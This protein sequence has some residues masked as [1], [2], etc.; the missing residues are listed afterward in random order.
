MY[1][2]SFP[3]FF[4]RPSF[5]PSVC[6]CGA[7]GYWDQWFLLCAA[8][9]LR[10][11]AFWSL[12][13]VAQQSNTSLPLLLVQITNP[14]LQ[15]SSVHIMP[16]S[17]A[18]KVWNQPRTNKLSL[19]VPGPCLHLPSLILAL[20]DHFNFTFVFFS[21]PFYRRRTW[22][23]FLSHKDSTSRKL[24]RWIHQLIWSVLNSGWIQSPTPIQSKWRELNFSEAKTYA[25]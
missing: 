18:L 12:T 21:F 2:S 10:H 3:P 14:S 4:L 9:D 8:F 7:G 25:K 22:R 15:Q 16:S 24:R 19:Q 11:N 17:N 6:V 13:C 1:G 20:A 23:L 5:L